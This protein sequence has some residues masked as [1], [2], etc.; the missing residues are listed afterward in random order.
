[1]AIK[2]IPSKEQFRKVALNSH[3]TSWGI[4]WDNDQGRTLAQPTKRGRRSIFSFLHFTT[5]CASRLHHHTTIN[6]QLHFNFEQ[7]CTY[8]Y[9][10][11]GI[12]DNLVVVTCFHW[13]EINGYNLEATSNPCWI[14]LQILQALLAHQVAY[15][16]LTHSR[17]PTIWLTTSER[18]P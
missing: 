12:P 11:K 18:I 8:Q 14:T 17:W 2:T 1:M 3:S 13:S 10:L 9:Q 4:D 5:P 7:E 6:P 15:F 16:C